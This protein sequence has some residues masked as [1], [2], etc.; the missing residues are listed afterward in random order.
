METINNMIAM[1]GNYL[2]PVQKIILKVSGE[3][4]VSDLDVPFTH[5]CIKTE[6]FDL[7]FN[8]CC[9]DRKLLNLNASKIILSCLVS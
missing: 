9:Y 1:V 2:F 6:N 8:M 3:I 5:R 7:Y 4:Y